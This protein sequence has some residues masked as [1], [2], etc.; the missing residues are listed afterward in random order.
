VLATDLNQSDLA[1]EC[2][3]ISS[4]HNEK[5]G[6]GA[7]FDSPEIMVEDSNGNV[8]EKASANGN[9]RGNGENGPSS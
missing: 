8:E 1:A 9:V 5:E 7:A 4:P 6:G 3:V 2:E